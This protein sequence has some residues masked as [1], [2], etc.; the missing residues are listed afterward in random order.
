M[1]FNRGDLHVEKE[2]EKWLPDLLPFISYWWHF[3][4]MA[5]LLL[6]IQM[7]PITLG[8]VKKELNP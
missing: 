2:Y 6:P 8:S 4:L 7:D 1:D 3:L 5:R